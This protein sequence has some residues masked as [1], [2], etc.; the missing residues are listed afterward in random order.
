MLSRKWTSV[1]PWTKAD[2]KKAKKKAQKARKA[3]DK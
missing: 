2:K 3:A 1:S